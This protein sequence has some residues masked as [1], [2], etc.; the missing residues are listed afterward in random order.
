MRSNIRDPK[1]SA[2]GLL[3]FA[4]GK[5]TFKKGSC[6]AADSVSVLEKACVGKASCEIAIGVA[7]FGEPCHLTAKKLAWDVT[8]SAAATTD[9][10]AAAAAG[11]ET[12]ELDRGG[13]D[14][15]AAGK[16]YLIDFGLELQGGVNITFTNAKAGQKVTVKLSEELLPNGQIKVPMRTGNDFEDTWTLRDGTQTVMQHEYMEFRYA[17]I[18]GDLPEPPTLESAKAWVIRYPLSDVADDQYGDEPMLAVSTLRPPAAM[19]TFQSSNSSLD[20]VWGLV[21]Y[22]LVAVSLDVN[23]DSNTRQRDLC[24]TDAFITSLGQMALSSDYGVQQMTAEDGK[25]S[26]PNPHLIIA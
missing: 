3:A 1:T 20:A 19:A 25:L 7:L 26:S 17:E 23:T 6:D 16:A 9:V 4:G 11:D 18:S 24:H 22:T 13:Q 21:K 12:V 2:D 15:G 10:A 5:D 8:C 14:A